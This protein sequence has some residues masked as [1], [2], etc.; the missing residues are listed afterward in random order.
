MCRDEKIRAEVKKDLNA[1]FSTIH[2]YKMDEDINE[3]LF[4]MNMDI[5]KK[6]WSDAME[7]SA[8]KLYGKTG[9]DDA[10]NVVDLDDLLQKLKI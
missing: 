9:A 8:K 7:A 3:V 10:E 2:S 4:C 5:D 6:R 1:E